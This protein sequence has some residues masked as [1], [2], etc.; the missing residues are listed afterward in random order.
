MREKA[1]LQQLTGCESAALI[2]FNIRGV[3]G[4]RSSILVLWRFWFL[5]FF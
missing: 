2:E 1:N 4:G 3:F 5:L